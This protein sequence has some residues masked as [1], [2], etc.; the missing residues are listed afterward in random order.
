MTD[1][2]LD[3][4]LE[5]DLRNA[6]CMVMLGDVM[7]DDMRL[8]PRFMD[9]SSVLDLVPEDKLTVEVRAGRR[10]PYWDNSG[11]EDVSN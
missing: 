2:V 6:E 8:L 9:L 3:S 4:L 1:R 11:W 10:I 5:R 7:G